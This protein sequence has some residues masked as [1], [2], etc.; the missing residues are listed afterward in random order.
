MKRTMVFLLALVLALVGVAQA[1]NTFVLLSEDF[2]GLPLGPNVDEAVAGDTV[3]TDIP[4]AGWI[5]DASGVPGIEDPATDGVTEW[6]GWG[7]ANKDWW[8]TTAEDQ[9]RTEFTLGQGTV[10]I[11]DPDEWDDAGHPG[12]IAD[13]PYDVWLSTAPIDLS[14]ARPGTVKLQ[15]DSSWRPEYDDSYHQTANITVSFD[16]AEPIEV[17]LWESNSTSPNYK[18]DNSTNETIVLDIPNPAGAT[19]MV[20]TFG[21]FDAGND[22]WWAIDN[23]VVT[24]GWSGVRASNP[25]PDNGAV[26]V[27]V[28]TGMSWTPGQYVGASSPKHKVILSDDL[29]AVT[30]GTAVVSTQDPN[31]YDATGQLG[32]STTY[33]WRIDEANGVGWD[34]GNIWNFTTEAFAYAIEN[35]VA[36]SNGTSDSTAGSENTIN[37]SGLN[38]NDQH[39]TK[40]SDMWLANA[41]ADEA[42]YIQYE[43]DSVYKLYQMLV[44]NYN[45]E[46]ELILGFGLKGV[47]V[48]YSQDGTDWTALGDVELAKATAKATYLANTTIDFDGVAAKYVRLTVN[49]GWGMMGQYGL[50]EVRFMSI[51]AQAREPQPADGATNVE[52]DTA[53]SWR[54]GREAVSHKVYLGTSPDALTLAGTVGAAT[55]APSN[56]EFG[57]TYYW[58]VDEVNEADTVAVWPSPVWSFTV[59]DYAVVDDFEAYNDDIE[60]KTT[61]FDTWL[62]GWV[63][64]TGSTVGYFSAP[65][66]ERT[67]VHGGRQ[68]MPLTYD[69]S[70]SPFYSE[71]ELRRGSGLDDRRRRQPE[72]VFPGRRDEFAAD[73]LCHAG[74][75][76]RTHGDCPWYGPGRRPGD[77]VATVADCSE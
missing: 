60:A 66:A 36:T 33:Y 32:F 2:E 63:N 27:A 38:A 39:S 19:S 6:A 58:R 10:A 3:W 26:E 61:I 48:T 1:Q 35:V 20:V 7:F 73:A 70:V 23:I 65:F 67:I 5:N 53:L 57:G 68:S 42:L 43:F 29:N 69:N 37:G 56:L 17:L 50:S 45:A 9:R 8:A 25:Y 59:A 40:T 76:R 55:F 52:I 24:G 77:R 22:W 34:E 30:N 13:N 16:G 51:P 72:T 31:N 41:P 75:P 15:F 18:D 46:F 12:P 47:T 74:R 44:W 11:A 4:P 54:G 49:S 14:S 64:N 71:A 21:L 62:D 28:K